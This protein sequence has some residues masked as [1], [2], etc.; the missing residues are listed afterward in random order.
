MTVLFLTLAYPNHQDEN[1]YS[2]LMEEFVKNGHKVYVVTQSERRENNRTEKCVRNGVEVLRVKTGNVTKAGILEK[3]LST[4]L[5]QR[6]FQIAIA[7]HLHLSKVDLILYS[8]PPITFSKLIIRM[9]EKYRANTYLLL[10][11]IFPQNAVD[12]GIFRMDSIPYRFFRK[13]EKVLYHYS[14]HIGCMSIANCEYIRDH[15]RDVD[16]HKVEV[17]PNSIRPSEY[18]PMLKQ[19]IKKERQ[20]Y[21]IAEDSV[22]F[23]YGG[24]LGKPQGADYIIDCLNIFAKKENTSVI[25]IG[26]GTEYQRLQEHV[27]RFKTE[28]IQMF[29][30][31]PTKQYQNLL[32]ICDVG[33]IFLDNR[34]TIPNFPSRLLSYL[35]NG[36]PVLAATDRAT[37]LKKTIEEGE[38]GLW[39][40][41]GDLSSF[42]DAVNEM[43]VAQEDRKR[44]AMNAR[45]FLQNH[46]TVDQSYQIII[47]HFL[48]EV[49]DV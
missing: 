10:K 24:N 21:G 41:A 1:L 22:L 28:R 11:D 18:M 37:D 27:N 4:A 19:D 40:E 3:G 42:E 32:R 5:L 2:H 6:Q 25:L 8:T 46:Y 44:W 39:T 38:F 17:C 30:S 48:K 33:M 12:L 9:K 35:D 47:Q 43:I 13:Q 16:S 15:N 7:K 26:S 23:V 14:D 49:R 34:F 45:S 31:L 29:S 20:K 36:I